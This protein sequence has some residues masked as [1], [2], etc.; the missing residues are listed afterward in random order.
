MFEISSHFV[1]KGLIR[2]LAKNGPKMGKSTQPR[3]GGICW[4]TLDALDTQHHMGVGAR[5]P[6]APHNPRTRG[7]D[8]IPCFSPAAF[9]LMF[10]VTKF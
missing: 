10:C 9:A 5:D 3:P 4:V 2:F 1:R 6:L 8:V 7:L